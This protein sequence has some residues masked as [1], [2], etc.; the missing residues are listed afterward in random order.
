MVRLRLREICVAAMLCAVFHTVASAQEE[1]NKLGW[2]DKA[3]L[4]WVVARGNSE[5]S[6]FGFRNDLTN[7]WS[8]A[9]FKFEVA[10]LRTATATVT[11]VPVGSSPDDFEVE[12]SSVSELT[13]EN[14]LARAKYDRN[15]TER[16]YLYGSGGWDRNEFSGIRNRYF[17]AGGV[18]NIWFD[19]DVFRWRTDYGI[20]VTREQ[21]TV[22]D[23]VTFAGL[24]LSSDFLRKLTG[25]TELTNL[26]IADE[27]FD[28][29]SDFRLDS[30][31]AVAVSLNSHMA[32]KVGLRFLFDNDPSFIE[33]PLEFP[34]GNPL[35]ILVPVQA[36]K[37][38]TTFSTALVINF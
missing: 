1:E 20:S 13:A 14:Y 36:D 16:F 9:L 15:I 38:D 35:G 25:N 8:N 10:G 7:T 2:A 4:S 6:M 22:A 31:T 5:A 19:R 3:E 21:G 28:N 18:G 37:L 34:K 27:N 33:V 29:T 12:R 30:L 17:G 32:L 23:I 24:R 11:R 26:T